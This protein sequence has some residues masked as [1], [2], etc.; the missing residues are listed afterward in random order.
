MNF[1]E[2]SWMDKPGHMNNMLL[3]IEMIDRWS[4]ME[5]F[6]NVHPVCCNLTKQVTF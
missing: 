1:W 3:K 6:A 5:N 2:I 4:Q